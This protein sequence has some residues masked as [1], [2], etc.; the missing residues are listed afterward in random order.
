MKVELQERLSIK[1]IT[2]P[3][4]SSFLR[5]LLVLFNLPGELL[6]CPF[7]SHHEDFTNRT[8]VS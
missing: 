6:I 3:Y 1:L 4:A 8:N 7:I 5:T 2:H